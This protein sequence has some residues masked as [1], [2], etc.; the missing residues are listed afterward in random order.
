MIWFLCIALFSCLQVQ[1][2]P[3]KIPNNMTRYMKTHPVPP[4]DI[5]KQEITDFDKKPFNRSVIGTVDEYAM[6]YNPILN[7]TEPFPIP[8][9]VFMVSNAKDALQLLNQ[10]INVSWHY[11]PF[12]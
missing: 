8:I 3:F 7:A 12:Q 1:A 5:Q 4:E 10:Y 6:V 2:T 9:K 11:Y